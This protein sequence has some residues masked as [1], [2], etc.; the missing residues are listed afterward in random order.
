[1]YL[2]AVTGGIGSGKST[3]AARL[4]HHGAQVIDLDEVAREIVQ[5]GE[6]ALEEIAARFGQDVV[7]ADGTL[8]RAELARR[9]F[10]DDDSR[11]DLDR[12]THPRVASRIA[13]R[14]TVLAAEAHADPTRI[15]VVDHPL[16]IET[17]QAGRFDAVVAV[18]ADETLRIERL[19]ERRGLD[20]DDVR[21]RMRQQVD[22]D[23]R[24]AAADH[25][26]TNEGDLDTLN[27]EVDRLQAHL[28]AKAR[29][30]RAT[31]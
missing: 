21:A 30:Q 20:A 11:R 16:L 29:E 10:V 2:V 19:V 17:G 12:I 27:A 26:V 6:P 28:A 8:D 23:A 14:L 24:R 5:P 31:R 7:Q 4:A 15:I 18:L 22:D 25:V 13:E 9:A 1:M 3:V